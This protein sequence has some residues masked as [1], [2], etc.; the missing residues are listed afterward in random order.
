MGSVRLEPHN[1]VIAYYAEGHEPKLDFSATPTYIRKID[2][3]E[4][5]L[6]RRYTPY[7]HYHIGR[8]AFSVMYCMLWVMAMTYF[9][10]EFLKRSGPIEANSIWGSRAILFAL[11]ASFAIGLFWQWLFAKTLKR[12]SAAE[13]KDLREEL[14]LVQV[15]ECTRLIQL[16]DCNWDSRRGGLPWLADL[17]D[18]KY[19]YLQG[20][21]LDRAVQEGSFPASS[22]EVARAPSS[23]WGLALHQ[24]KSGNVCVEKQDVAIDQDCFDGTALMLP[25][26]HHD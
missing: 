12:E 11:A 8:R 22:F 26:L 13:L 2:R 23:G 3:K 15:V 6:L 9:V 5:Q 19:L 18:K 24:I 21:Y 10:V 17:G 25:L 4:A 20:A 1:R 14:V 16:E 7:Y